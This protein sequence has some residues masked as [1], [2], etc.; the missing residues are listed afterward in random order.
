MHL[1]ASDCDDAWFSPSSQPGS[2]RPRRSD[3]PRWAARLD[4]PFKQGK[5][6]TLLLVKTPHSSVEASGPGSARAVFFHENPSLASFQ[7]AEARTSQAA[8]W[9]KTTPL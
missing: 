4:R 6:A 2:W 9:T 5:K 1:D 7:A 3:P 8:E